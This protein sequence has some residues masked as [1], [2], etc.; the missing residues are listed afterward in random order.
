MRPR[1]TAINVNLPL[2][3]TWAENGTH[4]S[5]RWC[6][7]LNRQET[8]H[9]SLLRAAKRVK[10]QKI[11]EAQ[12]VQHMIGCT[13]GMATRTFIGRLSVTLSGSNVKTR[14]RGQE[15]TSVLMVG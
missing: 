10:K 11:E 2:A 13:E 1:G 4:L 14:Q 5:K 15:T 7:P 12:E 3:L 9:A 6:C 8:G